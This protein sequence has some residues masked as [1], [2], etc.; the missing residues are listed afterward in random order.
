MP[1]GRLLDPP[2]VPL[3]APDGDDLPVGVLGDVVAPVLLRLMEAPVGGEVPAAPE[4]PEPEHRFGAR[5]APAG[6]GAV[7]PILDQVPAGPFDHAGADA[8]FKRPPCGG[9]ISPLPL[10]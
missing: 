6:P 3:A 4:R 2:Q 1:C 5:E 10:S 9:L 8:G 7:H